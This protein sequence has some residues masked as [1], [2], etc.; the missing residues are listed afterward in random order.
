M[1]FVN[2][3]FRMY[4][5]KDARINKMLLLFCNVVYLINIHYTSFVFIYFIRAYMLRFHKTKSS[6]KDSN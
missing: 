2:N 5:E 1:L 3:K 6:L 4:H